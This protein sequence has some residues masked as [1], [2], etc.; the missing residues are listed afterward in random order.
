MKGAKSSIF[1]DFKKRKCRIGRVDGNR[2]ISLS[3]GR[4]DYDEHRS[5]SALN[6]RTP[7][8]FAASCRMQKE[9]NGCERERS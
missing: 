1:Y 9:I 5:H 8:E 7:A 2:I 4:R 3:A 6:Y